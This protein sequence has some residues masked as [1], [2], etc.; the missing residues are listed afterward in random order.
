MPTASDFSENALVW[1]AVA[2][3]I[4]R[5]VEEVPA[6]GV[7]GSERDRVQ[8]AV[9]APPSGRELLAGG[10]DLLGIGDVELEHVGRRRQTPRGL[11]R[12][13]H[14]TAEVRQ[15]DLGAVLL[16]GARRGEGDRL[17]GEDARDEELLAL[18]H[19]VAGA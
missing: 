2:T 12:E 11:L 14:R 17:R 10:V 19:H 9:E 3:D 13:A 15:H 16:G 5:R 8:D 1:I 18:E 4:P 7:L 6:E